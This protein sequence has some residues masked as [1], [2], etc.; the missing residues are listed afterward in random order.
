[1]FKDKND[2]CH[3]LLCKTTVAPSDGLGTTLN[4]AA[5][6][7]IHVFV[8]QIRPVK[9]LLIFSYGS[10]LLCSSVSKFVTPECF[11]FFCFPNDADSFV[12]VD[13]NKTHPWKNVIKSF[14]F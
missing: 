6:S 10:L 13:V 4:N 14:Y 5:Y 1:M 8:Y 7:F 11:V 3:F 12:F 2:V 9:L